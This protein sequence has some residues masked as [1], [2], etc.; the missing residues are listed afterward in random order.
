MAITPSQE[1]M[2]IQKYEFHEFL[3][4]NLLVYFAE[5]RPNNQIT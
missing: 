3:K 4:R 2:P 5:Y 1:G